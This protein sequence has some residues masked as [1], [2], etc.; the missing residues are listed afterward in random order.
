L[1]FKQPLFDEIG[2]LPVQ[3]AAR[4]VGLCQNIGKSHRLFGR[5]DDVEHRH[6]LAQSSGIGVRADP[7]RLPPGLAD[8][9]PHT[10]PAAVPRFVHIPSPGLTLHP[11]IAA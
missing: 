5:G 6:R 4:L 7:G 3:G 9:L 2:Q 10:S 11:S 8:R 1:R